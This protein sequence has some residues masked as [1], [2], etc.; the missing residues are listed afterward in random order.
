M[1]LSQW[2]SGEAEKGWTVPGGKDGDNKGT[3]GIS[4]FLG[5]AKLQ[6]WAD[7]LAELG[8]GARDGSNEGCLC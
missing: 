5:R 3:S 2:R 8:E 7:D 1:L 4:R 6:R